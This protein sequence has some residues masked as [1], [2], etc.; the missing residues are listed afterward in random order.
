MS[1]QIRQRSYTNGKF[2]RPKPTVV[3][4]PES[5]LLV[6]ASSWGTTDAG[7]RAAH[8]LIDQFETLSQDDVTT[9]YEMMPSL[10]SAANRLRL[11]AVA[12]NQTFY[13]SE[14]AKLWRAA[15]E[16]AAVHFEKNVFS[17][18]Q[19]GAPHLLLLQNEDLHPL[20]YEPDLAFEVGNVGPLFSRAIGV[21]SQVLVRAGSMRVRGD[22][23]LLMLSRSTLPRKIFA[24]AQFDE[25]SI[26]DILTKDD[27]DEPFW[28]GL[29]DFSE[30]HND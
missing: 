21:D 8:L 18:V 12:A 26:V 14:N 2:F 29:I 10:T 28:L 22:A 9:P 3:E 15:V 4:R 20:A 6:V 19:V 11:G 1:I 24:S 13:R 16:V 30:S 25:K 17:F 23:K 27:P 5:H 7:G